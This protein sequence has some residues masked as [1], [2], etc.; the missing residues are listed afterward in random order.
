[1][2]ISVKIQDVFI[3]LLLIVQ[4]SCMNVK[5]AKRQ[6]KQ[7][8]Y[9]INVFDNKCSEIED[10]RDL[11]VL[12]FES[13]FNH[14]LIEVVVNHK[15]II[16]ERITTDDRGGVAKIIELGKL[17]EV[18]AISFSINNGK[19]IT[20]NNKCNFIFVNY[21][22]DSIVDVDFSDKFYGYY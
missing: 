16:K 7:D 9:N 12:F 1:M 6:V 2:K 5:E 15:S 17:S 4:I 14:D 10:K 8:N 22:K 13:D 11:V 20:L 19:K 18:K 21:L 3:F